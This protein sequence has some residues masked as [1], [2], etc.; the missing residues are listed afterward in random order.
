VAL[1]L[2][3][4]VYAFQLKIMPVH[5]RIPLHPYTYTLLDKKAPATRINAWRHES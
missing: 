3:S 5:L 2:H 1:P 4:V